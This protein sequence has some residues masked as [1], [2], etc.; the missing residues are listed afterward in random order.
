MTFNRQGVLLTTLMLTAFTAT[1]AGAIRRFAP[2]WQ[3]GYLIAAC[4]LVALESGFI[5]HVFRVERMWLAEVARYLVP[6]FTAMVVLMRVATT[7]SLGDMTLGADLRRWLYDPLSIFDAPFLGFIIAGLLIGSVAHASMRDLNELAP[8]PYEQPEQNDGGSKRHIVIAAQDRAAALQ[9]IGGRFV[10][11]G[12]FLLCSLGLE[13]V[14]IQ[15]IAGP[16]RTIFS[17]SAGSALLYLVGGFLLYSQARLALLQARWR[18][19]GAHVAASVTRHWT[20]TSW[21]LVVGVVAA[22]LLLPRTYGLGLLD[23]LRGGFGLLGYLVV[24]LGYMMLWLFGLLALIP[25]WILSLFT[26]GERAASPN[27]TPLP[28]FEPP[29]QSTYQPHLLSA[30]V[31]WICMLGLA[32]YAIW[33]V[34][35]RHP[36]LLLALTR[37]GPLA[38]LLRRLGWLWRDTRSWID[39]AAQSVQTLLNRPVAITHGRIPALRLSQLAPRELVRYFYRSTLRRAAALGIARRHGQTPNEY[40]AAL[41]ERLPELQPDLAELTEAFIVA[42]YSTHPI[43]PDDARRTRRPWS[44]VRRRL[45]SAVGRAEPTHVPTEPSSYSDPM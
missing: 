8:Q 24:V 16:S 25:A 29:P 4:F 34:A 23:T 43:G 21:L 19:D 5:H 42:H 31:F 36:G 13:A 44:R 39:Q 37:R 41:S 35:Q 33:I 1:V 7:F 6:E 12:V 30:L 32:G 38:W 18:L 3:P 2:T 9:R 20:R 28:P 17:L 26:S 27:T 45:R 22:T 15:R 10:V 11:G 14:N 40:N